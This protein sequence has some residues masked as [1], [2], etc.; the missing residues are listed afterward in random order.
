MDTT[1]TEL[2]VA[3]MAALAKSLTTDAWDG[4]KKGLSKILGRNNQGETER[5][6]AELERIW[7]G[8]W[9]PER[10]ATMTVPNELT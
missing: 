3:V 5:E 6:E 9:P 4:F 10:K 7:A 2:I 1:Q 8:C